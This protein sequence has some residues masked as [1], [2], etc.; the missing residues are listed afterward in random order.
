MRAKGA[1]FIAFALIS[2]A[3]CGE[4]VA[5]R[6]GAYDAGLVAVVDAGGAREASESAEGEAGSPPD[7]GDAADDRSVPFCPMVDGGAAFCRGYGSLCRSLRDCCE[8]RCEQGYCL[9]SG[10]CEPPGAPC[11]TRSSCCSGRCNP[12]GRSGSLLCAP[13]CFADGVHCDEATDCCSLAC[14]GGTCGG[15]MCGIAGAACTADADCCSGHCAGRCAPPAAV[16]CLPEGEGCAED[17]GIRCC[18][19]F[20]RL[21]RC[22]LGPGGCRETSTP[23]TMDPECCRGQCLRNA[24]GVQVCSAPCLAEGQNCNSDGDCC[25]GSCRGNPSLCA[26]PAPICP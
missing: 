15:A 12:T 13:Y 23:C 22:D 10:T 21:G 11:T 16:T 9:P 8:G 3:G 25:G 1:L 4:D 24:Q 18:S 26:A 7:E 2:T 6:S 19:G 5:F 14:N 20:C 17:G